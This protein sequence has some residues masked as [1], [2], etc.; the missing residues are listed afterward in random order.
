MDYILN[1]INTCN[2]DELTKKVFNQRLSSQSISTYTQCLNSDEEIALMHKLLEPDGKRWFDFACKYTKSYPLSNHAVMRLV[3]HIDN[4]NAKALLEICLKKY[5][6]GQLESLAI[7]E[8]IRRKN[9]LDNDF[10]AVF[11]DSARQNYDS[12]AYELA[13][14]DEK[15]CKRYVNAACSYRSQY[16]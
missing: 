1:L 9:K 4:S 16:F 13:M 14:I 6:I 7:C 11:C 8:Q 10:L 12:V 3:E 5:G 15:W 2:I